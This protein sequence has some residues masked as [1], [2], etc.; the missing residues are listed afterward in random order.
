MLT[1]PSTVPTRINIYK[2]RKETKPRFETEAQ[3]KNSISALTR[4]SNAA[5]TIPQKIQPLTMRFV[6]Q[7]KETNKQK[8]DRQKSKK[9]TTR[10]IDQREGTPSPPQCA[11]PSISS[12]LLSLPLP[13]KT[14]HLSPPS[15]SRA[16][17]C[18][19]NFCAAWRSITL[20]R[21]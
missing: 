13:T 21:A 2:P 20:G 15:L 10:N 9:K 18:K 14:S 19:T 4:A 8:D 11:L 3:D 6:D 1:Q 7:P 16:L 17:R 5:S 12:P